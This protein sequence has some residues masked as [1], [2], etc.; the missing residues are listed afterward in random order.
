MYEVDLMLDE[1]MAILKEIADKKYPSFRRAA[2][3]YTV[4]LLNNMMEMETEMRKIRALPKALDA[5]IDLGRCDAAFQ[6]FVNL[7]EEYGVEL[8]PPFL[9]YAGFPPLVKSFIIELHI[10]IRDELEDLE[11][12]LKMLGYD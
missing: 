1:G 3:G 5:L 10:T 8:T 12:T 2:Y 4:V 7:C 6:L 11:P 9:Q